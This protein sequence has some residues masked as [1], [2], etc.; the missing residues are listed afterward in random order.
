MIWAVLWQAARES[1][2]L[3]EDIVAIGETP[4]AEGSDSEG[5]PELRRGI[6][7]DGCEG[8]GLVL[9]VACGI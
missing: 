2:V 3:L 9:L 1:L 5:L 8:Y 4:Y 6:Q 7:S